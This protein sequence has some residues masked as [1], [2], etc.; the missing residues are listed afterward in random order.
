VET[1]QRRGIHDGKPPMMHI[2]CPL[3]TLCSSESL[4][5]KKNSIC[6]PFV[7]FVPDPA[8]ERGA[9]PPWYDTPEGGLFSPLT[10][11]SINLIFYGG[12]AEGPGGQPLGTAEEG[13]A[14]FVAPPGCMG[15]GAMPSIPS[16][17]QLAKKK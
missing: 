6:V 4:E 1:A 7:P 15:R 16:W 2:N 10:D 5:F 17:G 8:T 3:W 12:E 13:M 11:G 14:G 9:I